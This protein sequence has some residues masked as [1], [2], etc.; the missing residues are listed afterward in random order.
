MLI[1]RIVC[2]IV[3]FLGIS[4]LVLCYKKKNGH[5]VI[6]EIPK[7]KRIEILRQYAKFQEKEEKRLHTTLVLNNVVPDILKKYDY[8]NFISQYKPKSDELAFGLLDFVCDH[9]YHNG[10]AALPNKRG[11]T[12]LIMACEKAGGKTNCRGLSLILAE[13]FRM[14]NI[15]ARHVT[16]MPYEDP[17]DDCHVVVDCEL[18]SGKRIMLDPTNRLYLTDEQ[19]N[20][21]S[22][23]EF[24]EGL[25]GGKVFLPCSK[26]SYNGT[27]FDMNYYIDYMSKNLFR[28][29]TN[30]LLDDSK[31]DLWNK[32][33]ELVPEGYSLG[34][35][36]PGRKFVK[37]PRT[38]WDFV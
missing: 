31:S 32:Q 17:F 22:L 3:C 23:E 1:F 26:A 4:Y 19:G 13:L 16:C 11:I 30:L 6:N 28:F 21:I 38:F 27:K 18:P 7:D 5:T 10:D 24:R 36:T 12:D 33:I 15:K 8:D 35:F 25:I 20:Y 34:L 29:S 37:N 9:F 2:I 14:N